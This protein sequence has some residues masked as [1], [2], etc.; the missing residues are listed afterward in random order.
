MLAGRL[1]QY[2]PLIG[3]VGIE[4]VDLQ[5]EAVKLRLGQR[6]GALL[7]QRIL[8]RQH[9]ERAR[10][11][12][13]LAGDADVIFLHRLKQGR[14]RARRRPVDFVGHQQLREHR[15]PDEAEGA[16]FVGPLLQHFGA[17]NIGGQKIGRELHALGVEPEN[18]AQRVH[19]LGF[20]EA[21]HADQQAVAAGQQRDQRLF[22]HLLLTKDHP[23]H[24]LAGAVDFVERAVG[25]GDDGGVEGD[26]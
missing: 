11:V 10:Q 26:G 14:L 6:I 2:A 15:P 1:Q 7:L 23:G 5:Q 18:L 19:Q 16:G 25:A 24:R 8:R 4:H 9:M 13:R 21:G 12:V 22:D 17:Q 20:G 3:A